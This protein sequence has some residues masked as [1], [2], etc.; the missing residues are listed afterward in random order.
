M[1]NLGEIEMRFAR[2]IWQNEPISSGA[3]VEKCKEQLNWKKSTTYT[4]IRKLC[5]RGIFKSEGGVLTS[6]VSEQQYSAMR[7]EQFVEEE[8]FG[9]LP[10]FLTAFSSR[11]KLSD[12]EIEQIRAIIDAHEEGK[13]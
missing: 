13:I 8:F 7:S 6:L 3:L 5:E 1:Y 2:I 12:R 10:G 9:S 4:V 11:K